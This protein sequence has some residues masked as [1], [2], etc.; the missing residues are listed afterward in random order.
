MSKKIKFVLGG[1]TFELPE[2]FLV[3][4]DIFGKPLKNPKIYMSHVASASVVKQY[5]KKKYPKVVVSASS[6]SY[7]GGCSARIYLS[8]EKG[9]GVSES[10][11]KDVNLFK[12]QFVYGKFDGMYDVYEYDWKEGSTDNGTII[13]AGVKY[14]FVENRPKFGTLPDCVRMLKEMTTTTQ[15]VFGM[16]SLENAIDRLR[17]YKI[18]ESTIEKAVKLL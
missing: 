16:I 9:N 1:I 13:E 17:G 12:S 10:I 14:F 2:K 8:D 3:K 5:V 18:S 4:T 11:V 6:E 15:Y 7:S